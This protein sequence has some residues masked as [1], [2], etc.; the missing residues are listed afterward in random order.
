MLSLL[1]SSS[2]V[3]GWD[4]LL[5]KWFS[6]SAVSVIYAVFQVLRLNLGLCRLSLC[7]LAWSTYELLAFKKTGFEGKLASQIPLY[8]HLAW[9]FS[10][11]PGLFCFVLFCF[12]F[13]FICQQEKR[14]TVNEFDWPG[15][16]SN[17][18]DNGADAGDHEV[19]RLA[20][21][22]FWACQAARWGPRI[23]T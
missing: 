16:D 17:G 7:L 21:E 13:W 11:R 22:T 8:C 5:S 6:N 12:V 3:G 20:R 15:C 10:S 2:Q 4:R 19:L 23:Y 14:E 18:N 9:C 1:P